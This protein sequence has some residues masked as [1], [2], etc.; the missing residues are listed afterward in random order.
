MIIFLN[1]IKYDIRYPQVIGNE[2]TQDFTLTLY[3]EDIFNYSFGVSCD[4]D[5]VCDIANPDKCGQ[6]SNSIS[7]FSSFR[8]F[9]VLDEDSNFLNVETINT[10]NYRVYGTVTSEVLSS[11]VFYYMIDFGTRERIVG[12]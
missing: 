8:F 3:R 6:G 4:L 2:L 9:E 5:Y 7:G 12:V 10:F 1:N 11:M